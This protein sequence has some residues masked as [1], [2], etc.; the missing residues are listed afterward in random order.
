MQDVGAGA[1]GQTLFEM[2][3]CFE[4]HVSMLWLLG[5]LLID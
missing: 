2:V 4:R 5:G 1:G 3:L